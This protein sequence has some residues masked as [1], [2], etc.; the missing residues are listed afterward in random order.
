MLQE[1]FSTP[2][3]PLEK[4]LVLYEEPMDHYASSI[5]IRANLIVQDSDNFRYDMDEV[6]ATLQE[7][8]GTAKITQKE[9][10]GV[11]LDAYKKNDS[12]KPFLVHV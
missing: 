8:V 11:K 4:L 5:E 6:R 9:I 10:G 7:L 12:T 2:I 1:G 3:I